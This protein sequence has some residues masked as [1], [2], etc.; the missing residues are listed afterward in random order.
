MGSL[1]PVEQ[2]KGRSSQ[3]INIS[4]NSGNNNNNDGCDDADDSSS[5][6]G[7]PLFPGSQSNEK[8]R[9]C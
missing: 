7:L 3:D 9:V 1:V 2:R 6:S 4:S 8:V 5:C